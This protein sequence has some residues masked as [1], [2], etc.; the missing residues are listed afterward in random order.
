MCPQLALKWFVKNRI[1]I[2]FSFFLLLLLVYFID[3]Q[4][5]FNIGVYNILRSIP[6]KLMYWNGSADLMLIVLSCFGTLQFMCQDAGLVRLPWPHVHCFRNAGTLRF[7]LS[8]EHAVYFTFSLLIA[9]VKPTN[10]GKKKRRSKVT[11]R[12]GNCSNKNDRRRARQ[13]YKGK[14]FWCQIWNGIKRR[15]KKE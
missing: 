8:G 6:D 11:K 14:S 7:R 2:Y 9:I 13:N 4:F 3:D 10:Q 5:A 12:K 1:W 15:G